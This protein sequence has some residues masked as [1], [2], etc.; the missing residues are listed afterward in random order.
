MATLWSHF[1]AYFLQYMAVFYLSAANQINTSQ[2]L[3]RT[4]QGFGQTGKVV[5]VQVGVVPLSTTQK[6]QS[7]TE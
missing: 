6:C 4:E 2:N 1:T 5:T 3:Y 7:A